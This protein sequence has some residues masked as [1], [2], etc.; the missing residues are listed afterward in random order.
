MTQQHVFFQGGGAKLTEQ[1]L[2]KLV[3]DRPIQENNITF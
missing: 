1:P 2:K 3:E